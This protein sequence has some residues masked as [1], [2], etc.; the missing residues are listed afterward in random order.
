MVLSVM[1]IVSLMVCGLAGCGSSEDKATHS[2]VKP[3]LK[4]KIVKVTPDYNSDQEA[5]EA[6]DAGKDLEGKIIKIT[7]ARQKTNDVATGL[8]TDSHLAFIS[9]ENPNVEN[10]ETIIVKINSKISQDDMY[11]SFFYE[12]IQ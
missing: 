2:Q 7:V 1:F 11:Y 9:K 4:N 8:Y 12:R 3:K 6:L 5:R 10:G